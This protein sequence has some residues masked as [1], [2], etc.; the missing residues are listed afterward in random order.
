MIA[1]ER[2]TPMQPRYCGP[3]EV[4]VHT[5]DDRLAAVALQ[6]LDLFGSARMRARRRVDVWIARGSKGARAAGSFLRCARMNVDRD[7]DAY[8]A[9]TASGITAAC[10]TAESDC[11]KIAV[12][13]DLRF[14]EPEIGDM[15]DLLGLACTVGWRREGFVPVHGAAVAKDGRCAILCAPSGGGKSTLTTALLCNGWQ[16][17]GDDKLLLGRGLQSSHLIGLL[18]TFNLHPRTASWFSAID[19]LEDLPR[20][21]AWTEKRRVGVESIVPG[22]AIADA[23]ATH[24]VRIVREGAAQPARA[25]AMESGEVLPT[26]LKQIVMPNDRDA[27]RE[28]LQGAARCAATLRGVIFEVG[29]DAYRDRAWLPIFEH[30]VL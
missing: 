22:G 13:P 17:L 15:E 8:V 5:G 30:A 14:G 28:I 23:V 3:L 2:V 1:R 7:G 16:T 4:I 27:A 11:W 20:Y 12:P 24:I 9:S 6:N 26:L 25:T 19:D 21:S 18:Q 29:D 10:S